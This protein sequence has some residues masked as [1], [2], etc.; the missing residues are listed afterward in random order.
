MGQTMHHEDNLDIWYLHVWAWKNN[1][2]GMFAN[3]NST[4]SC[5]GTGKVYEP[6]ARDGA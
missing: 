1:P 3:F 6:F 4:V 2:D 5:P